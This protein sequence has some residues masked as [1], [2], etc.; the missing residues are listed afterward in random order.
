MNK[1]MRLNDRIQLKKYGENVVL[2]KNGNYSR[3]SR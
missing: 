2:N 1:L 3:T